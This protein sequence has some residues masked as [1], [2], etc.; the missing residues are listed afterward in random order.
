MRIG[1]KHFFQSLEIIAPHF[2]KPW[3]KSRGGP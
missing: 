3:K 2:S 1:M